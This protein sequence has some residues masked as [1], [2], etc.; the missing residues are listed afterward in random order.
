MRQLKAVLLH[1]SCLVAGIV[2]GRAWKPLA[3]PQAEQ[4]VAA[5]SVTAQP[6]SA[7]RWVDALKVQLQPGHDLKSAEK[8]FNSLAETDFPQALR[9]ALVHPVPAKRAEWVE[10]LFAAWARVNRAAALPALLELASPQLQARAAGAVLR[11]WVRL[12]AAAAWQWVTALPTAGSLQAPALEALLA[13]SATTNPEHYA[14]WAAALEDPLLR[15][16]V[17]KQVAGQ[18][19]KSDPRQMMDWLRSVEPLSLRARLAEQAWNAKGLTSLGKLE[20]ARL[21]PDAWARERDAPAMFA[22]YAREDR[23]AAVTWLLAQP[24]TPDLRMFCMHLGDVLCSD[25]DSVY[26]QS[27]ARRLPTGSLR[28]AFV[29]GA[30]GSHIMGRDTPWLE[31]LA[32]LPFVGTSI[33]RTLVL[34]GVGEDFARRNAAQGEAWLRTLPPGLDREAAIGGFAMGVAEKQ[35]AKALDWL[36]QTSDNGLGHELEDMIDRTFKTWRKKQPAQAQAWLRSHATLSAE[37]R[38]RLQTLPG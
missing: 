14:A 35:P 31:G 3:S 10:K 24:M 20:L 7:P 19:A 18:W 1:L 28:D 4:A 32:L 27:I 37:R 17:L 34:A 30:A 12:D 13:A 33:E 5:A 26:V 8:T 9:M 11:D 22:N 21:L 25:A 38:A 15:A 2:V 29:L 6:S 36:A 23:D 16:S